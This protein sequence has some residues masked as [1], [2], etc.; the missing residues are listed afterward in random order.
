MVES[1]C[2]R[3]RIMVFND[4]NISK[5][6]VKWSMLNLDLQRKMLAECQAQ[7]DEPWRFPHCNV[8]AVMYSKGNFE[9]EFVI[10]NT[11]T[12]EIYPFKDKNLNI[13]V[14]NG[15]WLQRSPNDAQKLYVPNF[16]PKAKC[17]LWN[18]NLGDEDFEYNCLGEEANVLFINQTLEL[19][20]YNK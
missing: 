6:E 18:Q 17:N 2:P 19:I 16:E 5:V 20:N 14:I 9:P 15:E 13:T 3:N 10:Q 4:T 12:S 11:I 1:G 7:N 8:P